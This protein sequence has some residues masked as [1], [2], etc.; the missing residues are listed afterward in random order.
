MADDVA[1]KESMCLGANFEKPASHG[2]NFQKIAR[3]RQSPNMLI[4]RM[5]KFRV[6]GGPV[7]PPDPYQ[8]WCT[9]SEPIWPSEGVQLHVECST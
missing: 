7:F 5:V 8:K 9:P 4:C 6:K 1:N 2:R 3:P